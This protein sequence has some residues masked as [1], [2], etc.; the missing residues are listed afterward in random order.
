MW[1]EL[2][3]VITSNGSIIKSWLASQL[4]RMRYKECLQQNIVVG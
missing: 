1:L 2:A 4:P 3:T